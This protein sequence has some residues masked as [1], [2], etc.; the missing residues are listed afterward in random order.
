MRLRSASVSTRESWTDETS[1]NVRM[2]G[3]GRI[4]GI[5]SFV[6][7]LCNDVLSDSELKR[8]RQKKKNENEKNDEMI[9]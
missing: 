4:K 7:F 6:R 1:G 5:L 8:K 2:G 9:T 3:I